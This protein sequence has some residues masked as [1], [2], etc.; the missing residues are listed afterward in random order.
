L[1]AQLIR[2]F[3]EE[4]A[5][6]FSEIEAVCAARQMDY[7]RTTTQTPFDEFVLHTLRQVSSVT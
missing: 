3:K 2:R 7:L 1:D 5:A 6:Y 4:L